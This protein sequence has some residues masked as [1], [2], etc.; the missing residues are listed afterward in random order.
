MAKYNEK[1]FS[2]YYDWIDRLKD[3]D[4]SRAFTMIVALADYFR[5]CEDPT[6]KF[7]G[8]EKALVGIMFDQIQRAEKISSIN[9]A[10]A[11]KSTV[12]RPLCEVKRPLIDRER[13]LDYSN[14]NSNSNI[15]K[16]E[17]YKEESTEKPLREEEK[18]ELEEPKEKK[19]SAIEKRF[20]A[21][22]EAYPK[23]ASKIYAF[24]CF[25]KLKVSDELL[26]RMIKAI[27][28]QKRSVEW[29][30]DGGQYIPNP[31]TWLNQ[32]KWMDE[33]VSVQPAPAP[34][35]APIPKEQGDEYVGKYNSSSADA[36]LEAA[37]RRTYGG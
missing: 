34:A 2:I 13:P 5:A 31:S 9:R 36:M 19:L 32:G 18:E 12:K 24:K 4:P 28:E 30:K 25:E 3:I 29:T 10:N 23:K 35:P 15:I 22:W 21:F 8:A 27:S 37:L 26:D 1:G 11:S 14:S 7:E 16:E 6:D 33:V 17:I 20:N